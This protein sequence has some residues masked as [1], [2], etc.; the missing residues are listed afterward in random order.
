MPAWPGSG[1]I[2][3]QLLFVASRGG[4]NTEKS[5]LSDLHQRSLGF[6]SLAKRGSQRVGETG[7]FSFQHFRPV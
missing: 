1:R 3:S 6:F 4:R 2:S 5:G 7:K